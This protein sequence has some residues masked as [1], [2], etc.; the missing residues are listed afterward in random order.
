MSIPLSQYSDHMKKYRAAEKA[1][2]ALIKKY[3]E[4]SRKLNIA[5]LALQDI[6]C[7]PG[8]WER[9]EMIDRA[10]SALQEIQNVRTTEPEAIQESNENPKSHE[11]SRVPYRSLKALTSAASAALRLGEDVREW[12]KLGERG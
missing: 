9:D 8:V 3:F 1:H 2:T 12:L 6:C 10:A 7:N 5:E 11:S 4:L